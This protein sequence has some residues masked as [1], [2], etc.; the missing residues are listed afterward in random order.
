M[1]IVSL[2]I[3]NLLGYYVA[4]S[5]NSLATFRDNLWDPTWPK[6][7]RHRFSEAWLNINCVMHFV[8]YWLIYWHQ[9]FNIYICAIYNVHL[10]YTIYTL[11]TE[12]LFLAGNICDLR[13]SLKNNGLVTNKQNWPPLQTIKKKKKPI[14]FSISLLL[15]PTVCCTRTQSVCLTDN[16]NRQFVANRLLSVNCCWMST[17]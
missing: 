13:Q 14:M 11:C 3:C 9:H 12:F 6:S 8:T 2:E 17:V 16:T 10:H 1:V 5:G 7:L 4:Y 15:C